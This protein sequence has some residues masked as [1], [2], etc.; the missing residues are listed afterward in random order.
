MYLNMIGLYAVRIQTKFNYNMGCIWIGQK[1]EK[2]CAG[3]FNYNMGCIWI[4][5]ALWI[6]EAGT[7]LTITWD[8]FEYHGI[9]LPGVRASGLTITWDVFELPLPAPPSALGSGLT[10]TWDVFESINHHRSENRN[11]RL[12]I[13]WDVFESGLPSKLAIVAWV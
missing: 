7:R 12:T 11:L 10:I 6:P 2:W 13:T 3:R 4:L 1:S 5:P 9:R 8:V